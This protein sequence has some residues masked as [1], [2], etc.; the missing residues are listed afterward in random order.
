MVC[1]DKK[2][3]FNYYFMVKNGN[4]NDFDIYK[5]YNFYKYSK[6]H[7]RIIKNKFEMDKKNFKVNNFNFRNYHL[8][9]SDGSR[10]NNNKL[11][12]H[13]RNIIKKN[14]YLF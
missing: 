1:N 5:K 3:N 7:I 2:E 10:V 11:N 6:K 4:I 14:L 8:L 13:L 12:K 9:Y